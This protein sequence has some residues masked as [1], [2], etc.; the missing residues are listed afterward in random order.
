MQLRDEDATDDELGSLGREVMAVLHG[1]DVP[2]IV[3]DRV[4][5][6]GSE[7]QSSSK[8]SSG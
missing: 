6:W 3:N 7:S 2:L 5:L 1:T 8:S 4:H